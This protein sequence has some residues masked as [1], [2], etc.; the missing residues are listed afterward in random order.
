MSGN[1]RR[2]ETEAGQAAE[3]F[4]GFLR[5]AVLVGAVLLVVAQLLLRVPEIRAWIVPGERA[6]GIRYEAG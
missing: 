4:D 6:E 3:R 2:R 1:R 5:A